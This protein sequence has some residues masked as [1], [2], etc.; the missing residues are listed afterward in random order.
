MNIA[1]LPSDPCKWSVNVYQ[2][3]EDCIPSETG[4]D[5]HFCVLCG[6]QMVNGVRSR[7]SDGLNRI[8]AT[9]ETADELNLDKPF[10][11]FGYVDSAVLHQLRSSLPGSMWIVSC[12]LEVADGGTRYKYHLQGN[13]DSAPVIPEDMKAQT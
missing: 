4:S 11:F 7:H 3:W 6:R 2:E 5:V 1:S 8:T 10:D 12:E 9:L 13:A